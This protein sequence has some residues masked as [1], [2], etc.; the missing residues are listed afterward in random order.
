MMGKSQLDYTTLPLKDL[1]QRYINGESV[2][3]LA[4]ECGAPDHKTLAKHLKPHVEA[5]GEEMRGQKASQGMRRQQEAL[6]RMTAGEMTG[7]RFTP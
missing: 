2:R 6:G 3:S 7:F 5:L 1:A 4:R